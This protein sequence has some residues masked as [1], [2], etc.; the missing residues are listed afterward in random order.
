M[1]SARTSPLD[2]VQ[3]VLAGATT[4]LTKPVRSEQLQKT[5]Q[6]VSMWLDNFKRAR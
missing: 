6:R 2:E 4:Y 3:G 1:L 5:L